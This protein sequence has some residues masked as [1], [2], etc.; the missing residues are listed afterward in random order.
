MSANQP[1]RLKSFDKVDE[2]IWKKYPVREILESAANSFIKYID[3]TVQIWAASRDWFLEEWGR[4]TF[5]SLPGLLLVTQRY[6]EARKVIKRFAEYEKDGLIPNRITKDEIAYNS[7][8]AS[9]WYIVR[10][11]KK[12]VEYT[13][14]WN[15]IEEMASTIQR[16]LKSYIIG[17]GYYRH[18]KFQK[19]FMD[20]RDCLIITPPVA[21][22]MDADAFGK[23]PPVTPR[24]GKAVE[25]NSLFYASLK[26]ARTV[27]FKTGYEMGLA[28]DRLAEKLRKSFN[29]KFWNEEKKALY[30]VIEG[31]PHGDAIRPN[32]IIAVSE[33]DDLL[34][35]H[36]QISIFNVVKE[37]L[38]TPGGLRTLSPKDSRYRGNYDTFAPIEEKDLAYHQGSAWPWLMGPYCDSVV[39]ILRYQGK[40][41]E[42]IRKEIRYILGPLIDFL[43]RSPYNS[44]PEL[45]SGDW[46]HEPGGTT[47]QAWSIAELLR[48]IYEYKLL[49]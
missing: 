12:Y 28:I 19:I 35:P 14:D 7:A 11:L 29:E 42:L 30:D 6:D 17:T 32:M 48:V 25:I 44:L 4:D 26:F 37:H 40:D 18:G 23:I 45:F 31:D 5:I 36:R 43:I 34:P 21:T 3:G 22:W 27:E 9:L 20:Q 46:P 15:F 49:I 38:L 16:I 8:D 13:N 1:T 39:K 2:S 10:G 47:S 24:N 33:G 41:E